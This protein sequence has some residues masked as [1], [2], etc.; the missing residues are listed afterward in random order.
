MR[1]QLSALDVRRS[2][3]CA[4][5]ANLAAELKNQTRRQDARDRRI[6][7]CNWSW[8]LTERCLGAVG[9]RM[10]DH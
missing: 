1:R 4:D 2:N 3:L 10:I 5:L 9:Q 6:S 7:S 8:M